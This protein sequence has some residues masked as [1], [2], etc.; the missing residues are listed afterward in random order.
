M[1]APASFPLWSADVVDEIQILEESNTSAKSFPEY[2]TIIGFV[3]DDMANALK[4]RVC[5]IA[6]EY[7][8]N[9][10]IC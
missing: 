10:L 9:I 7:I 2:K 6:A 4:I 8:G 3:L 1:A 5:G